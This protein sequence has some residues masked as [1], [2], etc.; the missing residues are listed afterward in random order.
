[1]TNEQE[2]ELAQYSPLYRSS[3]L[4]IML[5]CGVIIISIGLIFF[6]FDFHA[7]GPSR[8]SNPA[9]GKVFINGW[10]AVLMGVGISIFPTFNLIKQY[11][12]KKNFKKNQSQQI[13]TPQ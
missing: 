7:E 8:F 1:M 5:I 11:F 2:N 12:E 9:M 10:A 13:S 4:C 6:L 3:S